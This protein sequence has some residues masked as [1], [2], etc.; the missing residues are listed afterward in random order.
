MTRAHNVKNEQDTEETSEQKWT[1]RVK[2]EAA[3]DVM[4]E[5][6]Q[7]RQSMSNIRKSVWPRTS[8]G[9]DSRRKK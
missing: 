9:E 8:R 6:D 1:R 2:G 5:T 3:E 7:K 4:G